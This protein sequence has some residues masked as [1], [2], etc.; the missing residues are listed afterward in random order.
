MSFPRTRRPFAGPGTPIYKGFDGQGVTPTE[1]RGSMSFLLH[2]GLSLA[3]VALLALLGLAA[4]SFWVARRVERAVPAA[5]A[6]LAVDGVRLHYL[7]VGQGPVVLLIHG[8]SSQIQSFT[9]A[10]ADRLRGDY[11]VIML[12]R[13]GCGYSAAAPTASLF[14]QAA[15]IDAFLAARGVDRALV[16]GHSLGGAVALAMAVHRPA[17]VAGLALIAPA[18]QGQ[19]APP[20]AMRHLLVTSPFVR[21]L[22]AWTLA[23]PL[24]IRRGP[25]ILAQ[26]FAP[27]SAPQDFGIRGG[28]FLNMR[29]SVFVNACRDMVEAGMGLPVQSARY[30]EIRVPVGVLFGDGDRILNYREHGEPLTRQ[31]QNVD[32]ELVEQGDHMLPLTMPERTATF[33]RRMAEKA[34]L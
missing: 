15:L 27:N 12:D 19:E 24:G 7:E 26:L 22:I 17:R 23:V 32:F 9:Y 28:G 2:L 10:L 31:I 20:A 18:S 29:P 8:L 5:G 30:G 6:F 13:P 21:W 11:R 25:D 14:D 1:I 3:A 16:C 34:G 4:F 33:I